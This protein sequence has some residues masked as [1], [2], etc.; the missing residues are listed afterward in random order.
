MADSV[1][2]AAEAAAVVEA[3]SAVVVLA[4]LA[5]LAVL[6]SVSVLFNWFGIR[7]TLGKYDSTKESASCMYLCRRRHFFS[8]FNILDKKS[9]IN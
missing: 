6:A 5:A 2:E 7:E 8:V 4:A 1:A 9:Y 3:V